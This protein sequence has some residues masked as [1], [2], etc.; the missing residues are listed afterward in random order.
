MPGEIVWRLKVRRALSRSFCEIAP[1]IEEISLP[2]NGISHRGIRALAKSV[3]ANGENLRVLDLNDNTFYA[4]GLCC[5]GPCSSLSVETGGDQ[6][7][8]LFAWESRDAITCG[9]FERGWGF[10]D[11]SN[12]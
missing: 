11:S 10:V 3:H 8:G 5:D 6:L 7:W 2:Q 4:K 9:I 1:Q 12:C